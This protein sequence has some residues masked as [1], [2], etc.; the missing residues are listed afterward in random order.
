MRFAFNGEEQDDEAFLRRPAPRKRYASGASGLENE[1]G[2][3]EALGRVVSDEEGEG[4]AY[5]VSNILDEGGLLPKER[6]ETAFAQ[7]RDRKNLIL[8]APPGTGK[9]WLARRLAKALI[10]EAE[11]E[12]GQFRVVQFHPSMSSEDFIRGWRP[13]GDAKGDGK[14]QLVDGPLRQM[15]EAANANPNPHVPVIEEINRGNPAQILG[16]AL[17]LLES[18]RGK[19]GEALELA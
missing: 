10:G 6:L 8:Q 15:V 12:A 11:P 18:G 5:E 19:P 4:D 16:E 3:D 17:T 1:A 13:Q 2:D 14:L 9:T 7:V